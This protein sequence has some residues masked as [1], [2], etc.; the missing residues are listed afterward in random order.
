MRIRLDGHRLTIDEVCT[1]LVDMD[2]IKLDEDFRARGYALRPI[3]APRCT[4]NDRL[5][6]RLVWARRESSCREIIRLTAIMD[7]TR[8]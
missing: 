5:T 3:R 6:F 1:L 4:R 7:A 8:V 2:W